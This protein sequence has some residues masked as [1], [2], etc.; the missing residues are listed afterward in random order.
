M[1]VEEGPEA[2]T[3]EVQ[4]VEEVEEVAEDDPNK[5][6]TIPQPPDDQTMA[7]HREVVITPPGGQ[8][9]RLLNC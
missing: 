6:I 1:P 3:E 9:T 2:A 4:E 8:P 7:H 5:V